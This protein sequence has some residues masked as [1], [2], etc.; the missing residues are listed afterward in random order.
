MGLVSRDRVIN[1]HSVYHSTDIESTPGSGWM[2]HKIVAGVDVGHET[3]TKGYRVTGP[4]LPTGTIAIV[5]LI[6]EVV[7]AFAGTQGN[8]LPNTPRHMATLWVTYK[9]VGH[10]EIGGGPIYM[11]SR[12][13]ANDNIVRV[14]GYVRVN[15]MAACH[16][17]RYDVQLNL[18]NRELADRHHLP[19]VWSET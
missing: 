13:P 2:K 16:S 18:L 5:P 6:S 3:C 9:P 10:W 17:R 4:G 14:P 19:R 7:S 12:Y 1:D 11:S 15:A 8:T